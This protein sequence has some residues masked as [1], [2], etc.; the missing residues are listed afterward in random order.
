MPGTAALCFAALI[1]LQGARW[2]GGLFVVT[3]MPLPPCSDRSSYFFYCRLIF[4]SLA[5]Y[6]YLRLVSA[7]A[8]SNHSEGRGLGPA[9]MASKEAVHAGRRRIYYRVLTPNDLEHGAGRGGAWSSPGAAAPADRSGAGGC[10]VTREPRGCRGPFFSRPESPEPTRPHGDDSVV[11]GSALEGADPLEALLHEVV[12][13]IPET[14]ELYRAAWWL[15]SML[16]TPVPVVT[17]EELDRMYR[18]RESERE[19]TCPQ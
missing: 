14:A 2:G 4:F 5:I 3:G 7:Y 16:G 19:M 13:P 17:V 1:G 12:S 11:G 9:P 8:Q 10:V 15:E 18:E 6:P